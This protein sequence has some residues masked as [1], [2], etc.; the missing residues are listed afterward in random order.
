MTAWTARGPNEHYVGGSAWAVTQGWSPLCGHE[1]L[2]KRTAS[3]VDGCCYFG[4]SWGRNSLW[5]DMEADLPH[6]AQ[7][8][9]SQGWF[10]RAGHHVPSHLGCTQGSTIWWMG[11]RGA[12][13]QTGPG[14]AKGTDLRVVCVCVHSPG[15]L[16][17]SSLTHTLTHAHHFFQGGDTK[18][19]QKWRC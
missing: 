11:I 18:N 4:L 1:L 6:G 9:Q 12:W 3:L 13:Q 19:K 14:T 17:P 5:E 7:C 16:C 2:S 8:L 10:W 15:Q